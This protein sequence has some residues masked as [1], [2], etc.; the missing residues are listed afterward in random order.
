MFHIRQDR[1][2]HKRE[3]VIAY[4]RYTETESIGCWFNFSGE[5]VKETLEESNPEVIWGNMDHADIQNG[6]LT[7]R[8]YQAF[9]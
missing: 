4:R 8:P 1:A 3:N 5:S 9:F 6:K 2:D 7:L